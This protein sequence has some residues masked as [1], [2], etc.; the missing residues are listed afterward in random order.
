L[1]D[2]EKIKWSGFST[3]HS[4]LCLCLGCLSYTTIENSYS[5]FKAQLRCS[6]LCDTF[7]NSYTH[8]LFLFLF[9]PLNH[10]LDLLQ[11]LPL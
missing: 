10:N 9:F 5:S 8:F 4:M 3:P 2:E 1:Q 11:Y 7:P 6:L